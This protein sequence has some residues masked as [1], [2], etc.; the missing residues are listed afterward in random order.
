MEYSTRFKER[1]VGRL[2]GP[3]A[4]SAIALSREIGVSQTTLS[5]WLRDSV[6]A[7]TKP[8]GSTTKKRATGA[9]SPLEKAE[10]VI[11]ASKLKGEELG[12]FLRKNGLHST[13]LEEMR[14]WL[15][16]RECHHRD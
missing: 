5:R 12:A 4:V 7:V 13:E 14:G 10:L 1:M 8:D 16:S 2:V 6:A 11:E 15:R 9:R 3:T